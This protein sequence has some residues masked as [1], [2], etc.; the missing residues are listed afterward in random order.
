MPLTDCP[1]SAR[2]RWIKGVARLDGPALIGGGAV[3]ETLIVLAATVIA[4]WWSVTLGG[5]PGASAQ[6]PRP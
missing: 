5:S 3:T 4:V 6:R 2:G 1:Q